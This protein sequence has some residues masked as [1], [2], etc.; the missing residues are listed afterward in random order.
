MFAGAII[1]TKGAKI[2]ELRRATMTM[3]TFERNRTTSQ[4][5]VCGPASQSQGSADDSEHRG[6]EAQRE[7]QYAS[8]VTIAVS[9]FVENRRRGCVW[10]CSKA[11]CIKTTDQSTGFFLRL[12]KF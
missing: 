5:T 8:L 9:K 7:W 1:G 10:V 6:R 12:A 11:S 2:T 4:I 3:I